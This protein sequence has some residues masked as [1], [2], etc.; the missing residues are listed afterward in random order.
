MKLKK[1]FLLL[2]GLAIMLC[3]Q[4]GSAFAQTPLSEMVNDLRGVGYSWGGTTVKGFDCSGFTLYAFNQWGV[5]LP[6]SSKAQADVGEAVSKDELR[7]G[8]LVFFNT[9]G[10]GVS[11]VGI[12]LGNNE[13]IHAS[14]NNGVTIDNLDESYY[15]KRYLSARRVLS[16]SQF[17]MIVSDPAKA[18]E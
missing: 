14:S 1:A 4:V 8:D 10:K 12:Y 17:Q 3:F 2:F 11:H 5:E 18:A 9:F 16:D 13:F 7:R 15:A 6:H